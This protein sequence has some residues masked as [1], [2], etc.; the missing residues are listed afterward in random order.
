MISTI[1]SYNKKKSEIVIKKK[2]K[3]MTRI[4]NQFLFKNTKYLF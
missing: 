2:F 3:H 4:S 1:F